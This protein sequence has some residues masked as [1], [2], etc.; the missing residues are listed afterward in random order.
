[1]NTTKIIFGKNYIFRRISYNNKSAA[2]YLTSPDDFDPPI[3]IVDFVVDGND[4]V[5]AA[6]QQL[7]LLETFDEIDQGDVFTDEYVNLKN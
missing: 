2:A 1:M 6:I 5:I 4:D 7:P 3:R